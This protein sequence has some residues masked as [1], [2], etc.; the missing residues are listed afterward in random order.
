[1]PKSFIVEVMGR[2]LEVVQDDDGKFVVPVGFRG[3]GG[4]LKPAFEPALLFRKPLAGTMAEN[5]LA[6]GTGALNIDGC[7][8]PT[9][10]ASD[11]AGYRE[12]CASVVGLESN[13]NGNAYGEWTGERQDSAHAAGR[14]PANLIHD[15]S[16]EVL[17]LFP[18]SNGAG[19]SLPR[20]KVTGYG[21]GIGTG[22]SDY[23][24]GERVPFNAGCGAAARFFYC[25]KASKRDREEGLEHMRAVH[26]ANGN[27]WTDQDYRVSR[28]ERAASDESGPRRNIHPTVKPT[29]LM[30]YLCRLVTPPGGVVL[31]PFTGSGS[32]GKAAILEGF[33]FIGCELSD[34]YADIA[35]A[36][37]QQAV[38][39]EPASHPINAPTTGDLFEAA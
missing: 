7:R 33:R 19:P 36:R 32:T 9:A 13:R 29:Y 16:P 25:A 15:G 18:D 6:H 3:L 31:D 20:V 35:E 8:V 23:L 1:M 21:D 27:K 11:E 12:K 22:A 10:G 30:R 4:A 37:I 5:V 28:G 14:F 26:R 38:A 34:E 39:R 2:R 17:A 24:G